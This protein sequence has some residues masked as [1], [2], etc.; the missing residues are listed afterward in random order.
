MRRRLL[1]I[2]SSVLAITAIISLLGHRGAP[3]PMISGKPLS[4]WLIAK[5]E[6]TGDP[7]ANYDA[8]KSAGTNAL[9]FL[10]EQIQQYRPP[11]RWESNVIV[12]SRAVLPVKVASAIERRL[13]RSEALA[14]ACGT[15][16]EI[17]GT[18]ASPA[19][20]RLAKLASQKGPV[21]KAQLALLA[22]A[23]IGKE[24]IP[25]FVGII[26][27][28]SL[29]HRAEAIPMLCITVTPSDSAQLLPTLYSCLQD[30][31]PHVRMMAASEIQHITAYLPT[32][33]PA[34]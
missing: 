26:T 11:P 12:L 9:P 31:D 14:V 3:D 32:N 24:A 10:L 23:V 20:P 19:I 33:T 27:N 2:A 34:K 30:P 28:Q 7:D 4:S 8:I 13:N 15:A 18:N 25:S 16:F 6:H 17:L 5:Y 21:E 22:L 29:P 1:I